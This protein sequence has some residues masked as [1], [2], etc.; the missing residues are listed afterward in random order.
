[1]SILSDEI[2]ESNIPLSGILRIIGVLSS[3]GFYWTVALLIVFYNYDP[4][5]PY[6]EG[7][8]S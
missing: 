3:L 8:F 4:F 6:T 2:S 5:L 7:V 1:M